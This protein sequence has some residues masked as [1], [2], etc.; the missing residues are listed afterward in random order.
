MTV[1]FLGAIDE[2]LEEALLDELLLEEFG[3]LDCSE[4][5]LLEVLLSPPDELC[6]EALF[7]AQYKY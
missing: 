3:L 5:W 7:D 4:V 1:Y 6:E 2:L